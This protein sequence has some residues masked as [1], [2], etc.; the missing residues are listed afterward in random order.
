MISRISTH[1]YLTRTRFVNR[2]SHRRKGSTDSQTRVTYVMFLSTLFCVFA[3][4]TADDSLPKPSDLIEAHPDGASKIKDQ[5]NALKKEQYAIANRLLKDFPND[6][7]A[8]RVMGYVHSSHGN[9]GEMF[10]CWKRCLALDPKRADIHDQLGRYSMQIENYDD[11]IAY[12]NDA[13]A[14]DPHLVG[15][16]QNI[17]SAMLSMGRIDNAVEALQK[18]TAM[19]PKNSQAHYLLGEAHMP[20]S[21]IRGSKSQLSVGGPAGTEA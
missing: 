10:N 11:A 3:S 15:V 9:L 17:G 14:I 19:A 16:R 12:W 6:F 18:E 5:A 1:E 4:V 2:P 13:L 21:A 8:L 7:D 20:A